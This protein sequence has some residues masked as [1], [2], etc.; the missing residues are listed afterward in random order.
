MSIR[1][2]LMSVSE[3]RNV[4]DC[5]GAILANAAVSCPPAVPIL[6]SG[7]VIDK[8]AIAAFEYYGIEKCFVVK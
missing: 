6:I 7:E 5:E 2:A 3:E 4:G 8:D 1:E